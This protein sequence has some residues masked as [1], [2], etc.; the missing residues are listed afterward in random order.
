M[1]DGY[2]MMERPRWLKRVQRLLGFFP[3]PASIPAADAPGAVTT[4]VFIDLDWADRMRVLVSGKLGVSVQVPLTRAVRRSGDTVTVVRP[5]EI[6][7]RP[8][9][10][11]P[12]E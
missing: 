7:A 12:N 11:R 2:Y 6:G 5:L 3:A 8:H 9:R 1:S 10:E 4:V